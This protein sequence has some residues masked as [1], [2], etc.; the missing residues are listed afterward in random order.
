GERL[1]PEDGLTVV[2]FADRARRL[3]A[4]APGRSRQ[5]EA[6]VAALGSGIEGSG[7]GH[8]TR[9]A[10]ALR[11]AVEEPRE[12]GLLVGSSAPASSPAA[13]HEVSRLLLISDGLLEDRVACGEWVERVAEA[14]IAL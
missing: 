3:V 11:L 7:L 10:E 5:I 13:R 1:R 12:C 2:A 8:G 6:A 9:L 14:G 4:A